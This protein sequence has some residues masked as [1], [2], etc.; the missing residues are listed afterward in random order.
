MIVR[1]GGRDV[2]V[3]SSSTWV[4]AWPYNGGVPPSELVGGGLLGST[5]VHLEQAVGIPALLGVMLRTSLLAAGVPLKVYRGQSPDRGV[6]DDSWQYHALHDRPNRDGLGAQAFYADIF[7]SLAGAGYA[8]IRKHPGLEPAS[9]RTYSFE[10]LDVTK[11]TPKRDDLGQLIFEYRDGGKPEIL[12]QR[13]VIYVRGPAMPGSLVGLS[14]IAAA[15]LGIT[16]ALKRQLFE[17]R[18]YDR[19]A[20]ARVVL[21]FPERMTRTEAEGW[22][23]MWDEDHSGP[24]NWHSTGAIGGGATVTTVPV[25]LVDAQYVEANQFTAAQLGAIYGMPLPFLNLGD[26]SPTEEDWRYLVTAGIGWMLTAVAQAFTQDRDVFPIET[27]PR[28]RMLAEHVVDALTKADIKT[29]YDAYKAARQAGW[30]TANEIRAKENYPPDDRGDDLQATPV[31]GA[32]N[33]G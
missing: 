19:N 20:E 15:R 9:R 13:D 2:A 27:D 18:Y 5:R 12:T 11:T 6:A 32:P 3:K 8:C 24:E 25:S 17:A 30:L 7:F 1:S 33:Q 4:E 29:R 26:N 16:T 23:D 31:G 21:S 10:P 28:Q 22:V 14:P